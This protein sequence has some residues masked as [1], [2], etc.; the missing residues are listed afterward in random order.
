MTNLLD[1]AGLICRFAP[2]MVSFVI[3]FMILNPAAWGDDSDNAARVAE[4][5]LEF[6]DRDLREPVYTYFRPVWAFELTSTLRALGKSALDPLAANPAEYSKGVSLSFQFSPPWTQVAGVVS[7]G[8]NLG[9]YPVDSSSQLTRKPFDVW[10][11]GGQVQYQARLFHEQIL[12]PVAGYDF[13]YLSYSFVNGASNRTLLSGPFFGAYFFL[14]FLEPLA[15]GEMFSNHQIIR[16]YLV[17]EMKILQG[18]SPDFS[19]SGPSYYFGLR[20]E[21]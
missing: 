20:L 6:P 4:A 9:I 11:V 7:F 21:Y 10:E 8:P 15:A 16:S 12:V 5:A 13:E 3:S 14:N 18:T 19:I 17:A 1:G 2:L